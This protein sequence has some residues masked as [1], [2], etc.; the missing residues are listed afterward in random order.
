[1]VQS[2]TVL[3]RVWPDNIEVKRGQQIR[4]WVVLENQSSRAVYVPI[5]RMSL[6]WNSIGV[7]EQPM[8]VQ[9]VD[10]KTGEQVPSSS[11]CIRLGAITDAELTRLAPGELGG[12]VLTLSQ[13]FIFPRRNGIYRAELWFDTR[14]IWRGYSQRLWRG[15]T[16]KERIEI[17]IV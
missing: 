8:K 2:S 9:I 7:G 14:R 10:T 4:V 11:L 5:G 1:M 15:I 12:R 16:N 3:L 6:F 13:Y 17:S